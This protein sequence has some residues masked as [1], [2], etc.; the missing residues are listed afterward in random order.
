MMKDPVCGM[1]IDSKTAAGK[2]EYQ[3]K[4]YYFCSMSCKAK[5][6]KQPEKYADK[7]ATDLVKAVCPEDH[8]HA[9]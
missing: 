9:M 3:D 2:S 7:R 5:F 4:T 8:H 6:D 1:E